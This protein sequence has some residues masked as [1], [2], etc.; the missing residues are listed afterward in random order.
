[1]FLKQILEY[2]FEVLV[3]TFSHVYDHPINKYN[4]PDE[5]IEAWGG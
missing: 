4:K 1:M 5:E 3:N 2:K